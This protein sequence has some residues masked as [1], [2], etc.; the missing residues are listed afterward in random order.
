[1]YAI[2]KGKLK[3]AGFF[4]AKLGGRRVTWLPCEIEALSI[5]SA[6]R[7][8][9][10]F[11]VQSNHNASVFADSKPCV[12]AYE[13]LYRDEVSVSPRVSTFMSVVNRYQASVR[14]LFGS[15]NVPSD[16]ASLNTPTCTDQR[17]QIC[18]FIK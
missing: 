6:I 13:K 2:Q 18:T 10:P 8:F 15:A 9:I 1:M 12:Q 5:A 7:H 17:C 16:F 14:H 4:S 3:L 11:I